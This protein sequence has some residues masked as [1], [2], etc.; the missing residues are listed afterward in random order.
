ML[1]FYYVI[2]EV[3]LKV[4]PSLESA[5]T[6]YIYKIQKNLVVILLPSL[7]SGHSVRANRFQLAT[8]C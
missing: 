4:V 6:F 8:I 7:L 5:P 2:I 1:D 3:S